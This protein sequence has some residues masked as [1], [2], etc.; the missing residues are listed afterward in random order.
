MKKNLRPLYKAFTMAAAGAVVALGT[1]TVG[2]GI[3]AA[4][5]VKDWQRSLAKLIAKK[6]VYPRSAV[7]K[8]IEGDASV[9]VTIDRSGSLIKYEVTK[10]TG[11]RILDKA[12]VRL[13]KRIDPM[14]EPPASLEESRLTFV[15]PL[16]WQLN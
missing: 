11:H 6:Q 7:A 8:E 15:L 4:D 13:M 1:L 9:L 5:E 10:A 14:P 12:V 16:R 2:T 3:A